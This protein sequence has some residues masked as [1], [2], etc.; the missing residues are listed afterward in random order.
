[1]IEPKPAIG[2]IRRIQEKEP[3]RLYK[4]RLDRNER[5]YPFSA[6]L[7]R[8]IRKRIDSEWITTYPE[9]APVYERFSSFLKQPQDRMLFNNG[10]DQSIKAVYETYIDKGDKILMHRPGYAMFAVYAEMFG[11]QAEY[12]DFD[13]ALNFDYDAYINRIDGSFRMAVLENPNGFIGNA[14]PKEALLRFIERC[15]AKGVIAL[16][17][18]AYFFFHDV[19]AADHMDKYENLIIVRSFSKALGMAGLRAGYTLSRK[20]NI[21]NLYKVK[22][23]HELNAMAILV[24]DELLRNR[25]EFAGFIDDT[26]KSLVFLKK[27]FAEL[28]IDT[29]DS[30]ANFL[31]VRFGRHISAEEMKARLD[32][33]DILIRRPFREK[34]LWEWI[35][36]GTGPIPKMRILLSVAKEIMKNKNERGAP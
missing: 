36:I 16:I 13:A 25:K 26:R 6:D 8:K 10:S 7:I 17:D 18:E 9:P 20:E 19:T 15:E 30:V 34:N 21:A 22:P 28:G 23:M 4:T 31:A 32:K 33:D 1:M 5:T 12:Q 27:G 29:S 35:R 2:S 24:M 14:P 11:A 3:P